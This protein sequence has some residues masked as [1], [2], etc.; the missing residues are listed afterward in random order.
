MSLPLASG[1]LKRLLSSGSCLDSSIMWG[2]HRERLEVPRTYCRTDFCSFVYQ[3]CVVEYVDDDIA[4]STL[5]NQR[6]GYAICQCTC[7]RHETV[8]SE[9]QS[10]SS[11]RNVL[12][13]GERSGKHDKA[14]PR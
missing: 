14:A 5:P 2:R 12:N 11:N 6:T 9:N 10:D 3:N 8:D 13:R 7:L 1:V 4:I